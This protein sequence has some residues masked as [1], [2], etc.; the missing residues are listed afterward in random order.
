MPRP[1]VWR[2]RKLIMEININ[3]IPDYKKEEILKANRFKLVLKLGLAIF[4]IFLMMLGFLFGLRE[5]LNVEFDSVI[6]GQEQYAKI[7]KLDGEFHD[8]NTNVSTIANLENDQI[9]W[10]NLFVFLSKKN[11]SGIEITNLITK[12]YT[13]SLAGK[14]DNRDNLIAYKEDL[15]R[16]GCLSDVNLPLSGL[17]SRENIAF[18]IDFK[19]KEECLHYRA[20]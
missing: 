1:S 16:D 9:Y 19:I 4:G 7:K 2:S 14:A 17:V 12:D 8:I 18:Q 15:E 6:A 10:S 3:L 11:S 5:A 13:V 20:K